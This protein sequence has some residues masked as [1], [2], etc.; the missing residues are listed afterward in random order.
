MESVESGKVEAKAVTRAYSNPEPAVKSVVYVASWLSG[1]YVH[2]GKRY[3]LH[4]PAV[5]ETRVADQL[6]ELSDAGGDRLFREG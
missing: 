6:L 2:K 1:V 4:V 5:V 3:E